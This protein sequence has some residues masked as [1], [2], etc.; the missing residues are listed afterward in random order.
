MPSLSAGP[1]FAVGAGRVCGPNLEA[2]VCYFHQ[3]QHVP[4]QRL[5]AL[6]H[7]PGGL[8]LSQSAIAGTIGRTA[9]A[10]QPEAKA[11]GEQV[12]ISPVIG[13][14]E[15]EA[16]VDGRNLW[17]RGFEAAQPSSPLIEPGRAAQ[18][19]ADFTGDAAPEAWV[20]N[21]FS[22]QPGAPTEA[23]RMRH[24]HQLRDAHHAVDA[25]RSASACRLPRALP[26]DGVRVPP[27]L[28]GL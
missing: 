26:G 2:F 22:A 4:Y 8:D 3:M 5:A 15:T 16:R 10:L 13:S 21:G 18:A 28:G 14:P 24:A 7:G 12:R 17:L 23:C 19:I 27:G 11:I 1:P 25:E 6:F 20:S 9:T